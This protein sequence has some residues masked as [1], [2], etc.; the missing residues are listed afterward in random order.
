L[1]N[2]WLTQLAQAG[3]LPG[4]YL[5]NPSTNVLFDRM[6]GFLWAAAGPGLAEKIAVALSVLI[7]FWGTFQFL[8]RFSRTPPWHLVPLIAVLSY[9][10]VFQM[11]FLNYY[12]SVGLSMWAL[13]VSWNSRKRMAFA[14]SAALLIL[15]WLGNPIP[16]LWALAAA[17]YAVALARL[18]ARFW[19]G[20]PAVAVFGLA[21]C[22]WRL[23]T[24]YPNRWSPAQLWWVT[25]AD[26]LW[27]FDRGYL[28]LAL[29]LL[30]V[31]SVWA[32]LA[33]H[34]S[35]INRLSGD[36]PLHLAL[37]GA[38]ACFLLPNAILFP[39][40][41]HALA[42][43]PERLSLITAISACAFLAPLRPPEAVRFG[44]YFVAVL[45]FASLFRDAH[46]FDRIENDLA[47]AL[48]Q[49]PPEARVVAPLT[50]PDLRIDPYTHMVDRA[51]IG[52]CF[53][54]GNYEPATAQFRVRCFLRNS[55]VVC[56]YKDSFDIQ[57]GQYTV[58]A[59]DLPLYLMFLCPAGGPLAFCSKPLVAGSRI[60]PQPVLP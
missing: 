60:T 38:A 1:Y 37:I 25:G 27:L 36:F 47:A 31:G 8:S 21:L 22:S 20:L 52:H 11:G 23:R 58:T 29:A 7:F 44:S 33:I 56:K 17:A 50:A 57:S 14:G 55:V 3:R 54:Y 10:W 49:L 4:I 35:P 32:W 15:A 2:A 42:Y 34:R 6:V 51:C 13:G 59:G 53:S 30:S 9:G 19:L 48:A 43:I 40:Y 45:F 26:Q 16:V 39:G 46:S 12:L 24:A 18:P 41:G 5:V 28:L